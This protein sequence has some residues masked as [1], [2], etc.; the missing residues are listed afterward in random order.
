MI[1][2]SVAVKAWVSEP[3]TSNGDTSDSSVR[4]SLFFR[5]DLTLSIYDKRGRPVYGEVFRDVSTIQER[6]DVSDWA[7]GLYNVF[8]LREDETVDVGRFIKIPE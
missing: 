8:I 7:A 6:I 2:V 1:S 4:H 5:Q 3:K